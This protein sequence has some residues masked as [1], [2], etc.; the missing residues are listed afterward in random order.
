VDLET[1]LSE[2][3]AADEAVSG[4]CRVDLAWAVTVRDEIGN[5]IKL[6]KKKQTKV[7]LRTVHQA[8]ARAMTTARKALRSDDPDEVNGVHLQLSKKV[9]EMEAAAA[10]VEGELFS[11]ANETLREAEK[12][13]QKLWRRKQEP[14]R[15][16]EASARSSFSDQSPPGRRNEFLLPAEVQLTGN[17]VFDL[18]SVL[19]RRH[20]KLPT[21]SWPKFNNSYRS[22]YVF[23]EELTAYIKDYGHGIG[24]RSL[25]EQIKKH[26]LSK[27]TADYLEFADSPEEILETLGGLFA[28]PSK[29]INS[30]M[31]PLKKHKKVPFD[32]WPV[33]EVDFW[34]FLDF[35]FPTVCN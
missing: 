2:E 8:I 23:K 4:P 26:C 22:Y 29:L 32:D 20:S 14:E 6:L 13:L 16:F 31:D 12:T 17:T 21:P 5:A 7:V 27:G 15:G 11:E 25:A 3:S 30:L 34:I 24:K 9:E 33:G 28:R 1:Q 18:L 10:N 19:A 35:Q